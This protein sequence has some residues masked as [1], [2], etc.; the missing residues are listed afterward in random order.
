MHVRGKLKFLEKE[1]THM[2][3]FKRRQARDGFGVRRIL[4]REGK[5]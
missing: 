1:W 5:L 4:S 3:C 2:N